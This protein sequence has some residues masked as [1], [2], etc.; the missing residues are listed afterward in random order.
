MIGRHLSCDPALSPVKRWYLRLFGLPKIG[1][2][3][4]SRHVLA[5]ID[6]LTPMRILDAG[7]GTGVYAFTLASAHPDATVK[8]IDID[9]RRIMRNEAIR[10]RCG[11][12]NLSFQHA[13][14]ARLSGTAPFD[15]ILC[16][17]VIEQPAEPRA[18]LT[19]LLALLADEGT[20]ILH[21][22]LRHSHRS[23]PS[24]YPRRH[25]YTEAGLIS[26]LE[27]AGFDVLCRHR[28]LSGAIA[29]LARLDRRLRHSILW[30]LQ[31][32]L[33][34]LF[35][36]FALRDKKGGGCQGDGLLV[37]ARRRPTR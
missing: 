5:A 32:I 25:T 11:F 27:E 12:A 22:P 31:R 1:L 23:E 20:I 30:P 34:P 15:L 2:R 37:T 33:F 28:T 4:R 18:F 3:V 19:S 9:E 6:S 16:V 24:D 8:A 29:T 13:D 7:C 17:D 36:P 26:L 35:L 21:T 10:A 14:P